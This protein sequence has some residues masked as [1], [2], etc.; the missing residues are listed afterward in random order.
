MFDNLRDLSDGSSLFEDPADA[1][2]AA[3]PKGPQRRFLG[4]TPPQRFLLSLMLFASV[5]LIGLMCL[6]V[7]E[8][9]WLG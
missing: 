7:T 8:K 3:A 1:Q 2:Y 9:F 6:L 5:V 4:L